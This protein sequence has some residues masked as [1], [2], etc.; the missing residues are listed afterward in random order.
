MKYLILF[1]ILSSTFILSGCEINKEF[2]DKLDCVTNL[3][4]DVCVKEYNSHVVVEKVNSTITAWNDCYC[5]TF[6]RENGDYK[7]IYLKKSE[8]KACNVSIYQ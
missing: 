6:S 3:C 7:H 5:D 1:L 4:N 2:Q 8:I